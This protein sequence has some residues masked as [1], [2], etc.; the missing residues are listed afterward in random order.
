MRAALLR[1]GA[2]ELT[3][4]PEPSAGPGEVV[5]ELA[6]CGVCGTDLEKLRGR[7]A[8]AGRIG[9]EPAGRIAA[10]GPGVEGHR[11]GERVF[12]HHHVPCYECAI[13]RRGDLTFCPSY[14]ASN[15]DPG[16][17]A[18]RFRVPSENVRR[19]AVLALDDR[20]D[21]E[22][23]ALLE[24]AACALTALRA[25]GFREGQSLFVVG[26]GP[27]GLLY[28]RVARALGASW[29]GGA[30]LSER[31]RKASLDGGAALTLDPRDPEVVLRAVREAT[32]GAGVDIA[33]AAT[34]LPPAI[35]LAASLARR[36]GTLNLFGLPEP[37]SRL[38]VDLQALY[39][40]GLR[41]VP[42][43]ATTE[44]D[45]AEL[46]ALLRAG[47][48]SFGGLVSHRRPLAEVASAFE[49]AS[50]PAEALKV[51]VTGPAYDGARTG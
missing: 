19:G 4:L 40:R 28:Q 34:G 5:V 24:P 51:V 21:W 22:S 32:D 26:L 33:V 6:T 43:Y 15:I 47:K 7:Y 36:A 38:D 37:G 23:A 29:I 11:V 45:I 30:E 2:L 13:C 49:L 20:V 18:E 31:R 9:H 46:H 48:L 35:T 16:G 14:S 41:V 1:G 17:F 25:I 8:S 27:V 42:T 50:R 44:R 39:L 10:V 3:E 12:V